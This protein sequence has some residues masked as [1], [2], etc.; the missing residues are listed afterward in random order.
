MTLVTVHTVIYISADIRM[1]EVG[2]VIA[3]MTARALK[4]RVITRADMARRTYTISVPVR[5]RER[6][7]LRVVE[8]GTGPSRCRM[9]GRAR[10]R[11]ELGLRGMTWVRRVVVIGLVAADAGGRQGRVVPVHVAERA[12]RGRM[13]PGQRKRGIVVIKRR[14]RPQCGVVA[15][16]ALLR[17]T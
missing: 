15:Q 6:R 17:E 3:A 8:R 5:N 11:E 12:R 1:R 16:I 2:G 9:A 13:R 14:I 7:V 4:H 10:R